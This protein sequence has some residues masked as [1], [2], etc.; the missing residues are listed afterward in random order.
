[1]SRR[2]FGEQLRTLRKQRSLT[3][4]ELGSLVGIDNTYV[5]RIETGRVDHL[6]SV[7][8][9]RRLAEALH[10]D[11]LTL[12]SD[13]D[14]LPVGLEVFAS[15]PSAREF[16]RRVTQA[17]PSADDWRRLTATLEARPPATESVR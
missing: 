3:Q 17:A 13:A 12:L 1:M 2:T 4:R 8:T 7:K 10:V 5:S 11:E 15:D 16:L 6:P 9:V 14:R